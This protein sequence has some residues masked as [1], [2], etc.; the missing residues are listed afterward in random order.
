MDQ[1]NACGKRTRACPAPGWC[2]V[3]P[4]GKAIVFPERS[5]K[6]MSFVG[7]AIL[8]SGMPSQGLARQVATCSHQLSSIAGTMPKPGR[9]CRES[10]S[11]MLCSV[12]VPAK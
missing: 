12:S 6:T 8:V 2:L 11:H 10:P 9:V 3:G 4:I 7:E 5:L 1:V